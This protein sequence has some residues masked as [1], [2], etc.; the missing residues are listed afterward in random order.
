MVGNDFDSID[1]HARPLSFEVD[2]VKYA[3]Y[4]EGEDLSDEEKR[5]K[6]QDLWALVV[7]FVHLGWN[8][9]APDYLQNRSDLSPQNPPNPQ[10]MRAIPGSDVVSLKDK[11]PTQSEQTNVSLTAAFGEGVTS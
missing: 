1:P 7:G 8:V 9:T 5:K 2:F 4:L 10:K 3:R 6:L 11:T